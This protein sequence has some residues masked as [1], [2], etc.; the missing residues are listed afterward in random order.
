M[1]TKLGKINLRYTEWL[2]L[3]AIHSLGLNTPSHVAKY[4]ELNRADVSRQLDQLESK[5]FIQRINSTEDRRIVNIKL[6]IKG[7][8]AVKELSERSCFLQNRF[9]D[10]FIDKIAGYAEGL[11]E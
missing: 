6:T 7:T 11:F 3:V 5:Q 9:D 10:A 4:L 2:I 8:N 1:G